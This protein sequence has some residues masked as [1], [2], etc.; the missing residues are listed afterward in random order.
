[1]S[2]Q[3]RTL[4]IAILIADTPPEPVVALRGDYTRIYPEWLQKAL[5]S[6]PRHDWQDGYELNLIKYDVVKEQKYPTDAMLADGLIDA[7]MVTGSASSAY[8]DIPWANK[9]AE[10]IKHVHDDHPLVRICGICYGH[11]I[12]ARALGGEVKFNETGWE[13][14]VYDC[15]L[16]EEGREILCYPEEENYMRIQEVHRDVVTEL[17]PDCINLASTKICQNQGFVKKF[18]TPAP[19]LPSVAGTSA[20]MAFD[21]SDFQT[22]SSGPSPVRSAHVL[23]LQG[24]PEFDEEIVKALIG[25]RS[26]MGVISGTLKEEGLERYTK[27]HDGIHLGAVFL[28]MLGLEP[29]RTEVDVVG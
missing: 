12:V 19:P 21:V 27:P 9:L 25:S 1:M 13:L 20:Y 26:E 22:D 16:T 24:H 29:R 8:L 10:F 7:I 3:I 17:P 2:R 23:T 18:I 11:Q 6:I 28:I 5:K 4:T 14:G 15:E